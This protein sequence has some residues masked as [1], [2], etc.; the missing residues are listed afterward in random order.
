MMDTREGIDEMLISCD[1]SSLF[2]DGFDE[3]EA[4]DY[5]EYNVLAANMGPTTPIFII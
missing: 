5:F 1:Q 3:E 2:A 4:I